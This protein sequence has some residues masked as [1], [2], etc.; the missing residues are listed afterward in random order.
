MKAEDFKQLVSAH[1][2]LSAPPLC[3]ELLT[4]ESSCLIPIWEQAEAMA[5][6]HIEP[7]FWAYSWA[8]SQAIARFLLDAPGTVTGN[9]V[10]DL[11]C[12][13]GLAGLGAAK[14]GASRVISND[15]DPA[16]LWMAQLNANQNAVAIE[17]SR[18]DLLDSE[19]P[20][21]PVQVILAGDLFYAR[22]MSG[23]VETWLRKASARGARVLVGDPGR[24]Y[25]PKAG[26]ER[27]QSY[28][29]A[30]PK[31]IE[32]VTSRTVSVLELRA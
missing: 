4:Q 5:G 10:L 6:H 1:T 27:L 2:K 22:E 19:P 26:L 17:C 28:V 32:G 12:G 3:P 30:V 25:M 11:G 29:I 9:I 18:E 7:P 15:I 21:P 31:E 13:N 16:A 24:A 8:G 23:R 20:V 14:S